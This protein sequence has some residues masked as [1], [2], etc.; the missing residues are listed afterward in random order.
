MNL[1][2]LQPKKR[3]PP[4]TSLF[5][6]HHQAI[7]SV[8]AS[9]CFFAVCTGH[10]GQAALPRGLKAPMCHPAAHQPLGQ[11]RTGQD[12]NWGRSHQLQQDPHAER[13]GDE[14]SHPAR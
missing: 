5:L 10:R 12:R 1:Q 14:A 7:Y 11:D 13:G 6:E 2:A 8:E 4:S 9:P 3:D